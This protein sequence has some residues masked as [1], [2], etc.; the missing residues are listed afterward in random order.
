VGLEVWVSP[1]AGA[2]EDWRREIAF[3]KQA[4]VT[5]VNAHTTFASKIHKRIAGKT[6]AEHLA[7]ITR[8]RKAVADLL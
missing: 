2:E 1:G 7:A 4:G 8:Y 6:A 3:W 5:H